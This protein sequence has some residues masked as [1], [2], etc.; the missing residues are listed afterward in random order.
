MRITLPI[1]IG[2]LVV[3]TTSAF[4]AYDNGRALPMQRGL[5]G[6][7]SWTDIPIRDHGIGLRAD[8]T[9][10]GQ[11]TIVGTDYYALP[12][13]NDPDNGNWNFDR[14]TGPSGA[15]LFP[16]LFGEP[17][18]DGEGWSVR[19]MTVNDTEYFRVISTDLNLGAGVPPPII[20]G[21]WSLWVGADKP[22]ADALC[23]E[24]GAGYG[25]NWCQRVVSP[26]LLYEGTGD[27][28]LGFQYWVNSEDCYDG[29]QIYL[30]RGDNTEVL[31]NPYPSGTCENNTGWE[32]GT[33]TDSIGA[34][35]DAQTYSR[36][37]TAGELGGAQ[38]I[39]IIFEFTADGGW[40]DQDCQYATIW[41]PFGAD[42]VAV[43]GTVPP[44]SN[45]FED[46]TMQGWTPATCDPIG[47]FVD[48]VDVAN[49]TI[50]DP[51]ACELE[52]FI[53]EMH[54]G[55]P[56]PDAN[57]PVGQHIRANS[58]IIWFGESTL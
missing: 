35:D 58:P 18:E 32:G 37:I 36:V 13:F 25:N 45:N 2:L 51:C 40:S 5:I 12:F 46:G 26:D 23:W 27:V 6:G 55:P 16:Q 15:L 53:M 22:Q 24:C 50:L 7:E 38:T 20:D 30:L 48:I 31:L 21:S 33:F 41:G 57:H 19:D 39:N 11:Y 28:L 29:T 9:W 52:G 14:G 44:L 54:A 34:W 10:Y 43:T 42:N 8:T 56:G 1:L 47:T 49:Y 4:A 17:I 3:T